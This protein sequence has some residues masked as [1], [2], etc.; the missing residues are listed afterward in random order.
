[1]NILPPKTSGLDLLGQY[2][3]QGMQ[4]AM[5]QQYENQKYQRGMDVIKNA[6]SEI[7]KADGDP[8]KIALTF[9]KMGAAAPGL[10]RALG[11]LMQ[12][13][14]AE[15][16][17]KRAF[18][19]APGQTRGASQ[20]Q[21]PSTVQPSPQVAPQGQQATPSPI[22]IASESMFA[23]P[24]PFN[25]MTPDV[26]KNEAERFAKALRDPNAYQNKLK[27]LQ[28]ENNVATAQR[29]ALEDAALK[30]GEVKPTD[31]PRYMQVGAEFDP[32]N[33]SEW[34][35]K[36]NRAYKKIKSNDDKIDRAFIPG[37]G[38]ALFGKDRNQALERIKPTIQDNI[39]NGLEQETRDKLVDNYLSPTEIETLIH[40]M[41]PKQEK[42]ISSLPRGFFPAETKK[43]FEESGYKKG[44]GYQ[45]EKSPFI[46][47]DEAKI[48]APQ[49][50]QKMQD[51]LAN[52]FI[53][54]VDKDTSLL[55]LREKIWEDRDYDWQQIGPAIRQAIKMGLKLE[56][57]QMTEMT[58][59]ETQAP[60]P[61]IPDLF[62]DLGR[63]VKFQR[64]ER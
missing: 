7:A 6:E 34:V 31:L 16:Q 22:P 63:Y 57:F 17:I 56:P 52:F 62:N 2:I 29:N 23:T 40:P 8:Y 51:T 49:E 41:T 9:A 42:A 60:M 37:L 20:G 19:E 44:L 32:S 5:P 14:L 55:G 15:S 43:Q 18:P 4:N 54:N 27:T 26:M 13:A 21:A 3:G 30:T 11:P 10:E 59:I 45:K 33:P 36:T 35:Q 28:D 38:S 25:V 1:M 50:L 61:S 53:E 12:T 64:G 58:D 48:R 39:K 24:G 47:Y 46:S